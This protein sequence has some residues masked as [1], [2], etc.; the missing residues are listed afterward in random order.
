VKGISEKLKRIGNH[1]NF[2][3]VLK[4]QHVLR[5]LLMRTRPKRNPQQMAHYLYSIPCECGKNY[6]CEE[7]TPLAVQLCEQATSEW[8]FWKNQSWCNVL[9]GKIIG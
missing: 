3:T 4:T 7:G 9:V 1:H 8:V 2:T 5:S 6:V